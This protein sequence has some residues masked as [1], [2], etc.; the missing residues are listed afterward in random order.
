MSLQVANHGR[1][2]PAPTVHEIQAMGL[3]TLPRAQRS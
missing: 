3:T 1:G 2:I